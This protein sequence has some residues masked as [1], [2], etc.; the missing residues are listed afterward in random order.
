MR[1]TESREHRMASQGR[2]CTGKEKEGLLH[3]RRY[4]RG[5]RKMSNIVIKNIPL[6]AYWFIFLSFSAD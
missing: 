5:H 2:D 1:E 6:F 3:P 4:V